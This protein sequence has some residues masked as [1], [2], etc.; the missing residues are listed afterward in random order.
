METTTYNGG[1]KGVGLRVTTA[2][3]GYALGLLCAFLGG[4]GFRVLEFK[5]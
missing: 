2:K 3:L 1:R 4:S 5:V